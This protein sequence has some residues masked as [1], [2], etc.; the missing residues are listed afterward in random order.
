MTRHIRSTT[1]TTALALAIAAT[2]VTA[3]AAYAA[4]KRPALGGHAKASKGPVFAKPAQAY[5]ANLAAPAD[6]SHDSFI[7]SFHAGATPG[8][9]ALRNHLRTVGNTLGIQI[10][11]DRDT[12]TGA[13]LV[14]TSRALDRDG[15]KRLTSELMK[16]P[17]VRAVDPNGRMYRAMEPNDELFSQQWHYRG[18]GEGMNAVEAWD[19][20][21]GNGY[22]IA[23]LDTG[24][25]D[26]ADLQGQFVA[27]YDFIT[28]PANARDD[29]G[30]DPD[31]NDEGD[32][33]AKYDSS[34]HGTHVAGTV[35]ALTDNKI[36]IAGVAHGAKVQHVR[37][38]GN[39]GGSFADISDAIVW[40]SG[41]DVPDVPAN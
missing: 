26:H 14:R 39:A 36:G 10:A 27:G 15:L 22:I 19:S 24:Q 29:D 31:P 11:V 2:L 32:W 18:D 35:A 16:S 21:D 8:A 41:G 23:V 28:D 33:D 3:P 12:A 30:R 1:T 37:V 7:I 13:K 5:G 4:S 6:A 17:M 40:A 9:A 25:V 38:L 34:W 20:V